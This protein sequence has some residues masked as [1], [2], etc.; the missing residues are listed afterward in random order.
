VKISR[1]NIRQDA[2]AREAFKDW[3]SII[4]SLLTIVA[5]LLGGAW[6]LYQESLKPELKL[7]QI[8]TKRRLQEVQG[9]WL[10]S[11]EVTATNTGKIRETLQGGTL[12]IVQ[13]NPVPGRVIF[14]KIPLA[15]LQLDPGESDQALF[16]TFQISDYSSTLQ[17]QS[18]YPVPTAASSFGSFLPK[19]LINKKT[20]LEWH[21][22]TIL[23]FDSSK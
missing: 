21:H 2:S 7:D 6:F 17:I 14:E 3:S 4:Q 10:I 18:H 20:Q 13:L 9:V 16:S 22:S 23:D 8:V 19:F 5:I 12:D 11:V 1:D 15:D